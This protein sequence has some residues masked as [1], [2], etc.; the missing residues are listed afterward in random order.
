MTAY[1][2]RRVL[3]AGVVLF[4]VS[5]IVFILLHLLPGG[6]ARAVLGPRAN[7]VQILAFEREY[8]LLKPLPLQY[9]AWANQLIHGN[10][11]FSFK[12]NQT[13]DALLGE[14]LPRTALL[15][16]VATLLALLI[17]VP[18][19]I[20]QAVR[21]NRPDDY[22]LTGASFLFYSMPTFFLGIIL[23]ILFSDTFPILPSTGPQSTA[24]LW[25]QIPNLILPIATLCLVT[26]ALFSRYMRSS[27]LE[28]MVQD[29]VRTARAKGVSDR[30]VLFKHV[31][32][33]ALIPIVTLIGLSLPGILS[34]ALV[35]ESLFNYPGM[36]LLFWSAAQNQ[37]YPVLLGTTMVVGVAV[38]VGSLLADILYAVVDPRVR[39]A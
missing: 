17:A 14:N 37:D 19:G 7:Q 34:G 32:R 5:I 39:Y 26:L 13:V 22:V 23:I 2:I 21:R 29:Y 25:S 28:N 8:G 6:P 9:L 36:G 1:L 3:Q 18:L 33:N 35:T 10:L 38:V 12:Q 16:G 30:G 20:Y 11:G 27:M 4:G 24:S 15:V 31:L